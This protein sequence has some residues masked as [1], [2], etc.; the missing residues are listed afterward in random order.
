[1]QGLT[2]LAPQHHFHGTGTHY[3]IKFDETDLRR[4]L[5]HE[6]Q[7]TNDGWRIELLGDVHIPGLDDT[8]TGIAAELT[9]LCQV[10]LST[11]HHWPAEPTQPEI[12]QFMAC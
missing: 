3:G 12:Q 9:T 8:K 11:K 4:E 7:K 6:E 5:T 10:P 2:I 1:M